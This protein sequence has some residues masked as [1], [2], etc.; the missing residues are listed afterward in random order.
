ML[1]RTCGR[2]AR[3]YQNYGIKT[4]SD[5]IRNLQLTEINLTLYD[6]ER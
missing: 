5:V 1:L 2:R 3:V 4:T 6:K